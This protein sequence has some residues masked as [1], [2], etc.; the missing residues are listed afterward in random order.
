MERIALPRGPLMREPRSAGLTRGEETGMGAV[1]VV[2]VVAAVAAAV[3]VDAFVL[4]LEAAVGGRG[5]D[6]VEEV[7]LLLLLL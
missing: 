3:D 7:V 5:V 6:E 2:V 4:A 1:V